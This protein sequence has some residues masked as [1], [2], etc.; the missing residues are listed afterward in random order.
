MNDSVTGEPFEP[1]VQNLI[2]HF[3]TVLVWARSRYVS[4]TNNFVDYTGGNHTRFGHMCGAAN[5]AYLL[6]T[7]V[8]KNYE[9]R[10]GTVPS[11]FVLRCTVAALLHDIAHGP[12]S[13]AF[14]GA[15]YKKIYNG[16]EKGH[17]LHRIY[18]M[19]ND[20]AL[21]AAVISAGLDPE[22]II[23]IWGG[24]GHSSDWERIMSNIV[25]GRLGADSGDFVNR[26]GHQVGK[27][28][29]YSYAEIIRGATIV[30]V[31][32]HPRLAFR[33]SAIEEIKRFLRAR[34]MMYREIYLNDAASNFA[35]VIRTFLRRYE[36]EFQ[37]SA[38][39]LDTEKFAYMTDQELV[40]RARREGSP[41][42]RELADMMF[43][44]HYPVA[45]WKI[46]VS[47]KDKAPKKAQSELRMVSR[48]IKGYDHH[49][50]LR[51]MTFLH[52]DGNP[53]LF[54][55]SGKTAVQSCV[56]RYYNAHDVPGSKL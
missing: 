39:V 16:A 21:R 18:L 48:T 1:L 7:E 13:H 12:Y 28:P 10:G 20:S 30:D 9:A 47:T 23:G 24:N 50:F 26:D 56:A 37:L 42:L 53:R 38:D 4:Q 27:E 35:V 5:K 17:D 45:T 3:L 25:Q 55:E 2:I 54:P 43:K 29:L 22:D 8:K 34:R 19:K 51:E 33:A 40:S 49:D 15:V 32:G 14:D 31:D 36:S 6:S 11:K 46:T 52:S 41:E 44:Y